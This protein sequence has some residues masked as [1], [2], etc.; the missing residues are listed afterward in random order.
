M[1][2]NNPVDHISVYPLML[3]KKNKG[4]YGSEFSLNP[5]IY[6]YE[7]TD[8]NTWTLKSQNLNYTICS[9]Y[10]NSIMSRRDPINKIAEFQIMTVANLG[11]KIDEILNLR[12]NELESKYNVSSIN[13]MKLQQ[14]KRMIGVRC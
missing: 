13:K 8:N 14:Y 5:E 1:D 11:I 6:G 2:K 10:A 9:M 12:Y 3:F 4:D 7:I